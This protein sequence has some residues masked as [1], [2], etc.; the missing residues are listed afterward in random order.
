M[1][2]I[3]DDSTHM[4][5]HIEDVDFSNHKN[6]GYINDFVVKLYACMWNVSRIIKDLNKRGWASNIE[7]MWFCF[8]L[9]VFD[10]IFRCNKIYVLLRSVTINNTHLIGENNALNFKVARF[11]FCFTWIHLCG[12]LDL[13]THIIILFPTCTLN[14]IKGGD[15]WRTKRLQL[16]IMWLELYSERTTKNLVTNP[17]HLRCEFCEV[18]IQGVIFLQILI[19]T[20]TSMII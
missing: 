17:S 7:I 2:E 16:H 10:Y 15:G 12:K 19:Q 13:H 8:V 11:K 4:I 1:V 6:N 9:V 14:E 18:V 5:E 3:D 20:V